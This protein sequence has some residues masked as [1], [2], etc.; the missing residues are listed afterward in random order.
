MQTLFLIAI[1]SVFW[2]LFEQQAASLTLLADQQFDLKV[3]G[4]NILASQVQMMNALF[5]I[6]LAPVMA[7]L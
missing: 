5:I 7:W 3:L 4:V 2:A 1:Q 6:I